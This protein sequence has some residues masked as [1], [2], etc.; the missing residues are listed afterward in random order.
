[1]SDVI[2]FTNGYL[3]MSDGQVSHSTLWHIKDN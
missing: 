1:M 2:R 3:A